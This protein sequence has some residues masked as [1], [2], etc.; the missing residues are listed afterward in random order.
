MTRNW[1]LKKDRREAAAAFLRKTVTDPDVRSAVLKDRKAAHRIFQKEGGIAIPDEVEV[2]C[3]GPS[4]QE[5]D[6]VILFVL[7]P[8]DGQAGH[9]DPLK[10]WIGAWYPYGFEALTGPTRRNTAPNEA[11]VPALD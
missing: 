1:K 8:E 3:I 2:I 7:P 10:H 5:R 11:A 9:I 6:R 4:T